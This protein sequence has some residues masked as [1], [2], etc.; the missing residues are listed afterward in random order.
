M[1]FPRR[2]L[3]LLLLAG[4]LGVA[5][6]AAAQDSKEFRGRVLATPA[7][8]GLSVPVLTLGGYGVDSTLVGDS[9]L[10]GWDSRAAA[11]TRFDGILGGY[12]GDNAPDVKWVLPEA[13]RRM[14]KRAPSMVP[15]PDR[16]GHGVMSSERIKRIPDPLASRLRQL[17]AMSDA[18][19]VFI[20]SGLLLK[21][22]STGT[23]QAE[24]A[25]QLVDARLGDVL[26]RTFATGKGRS[27]DAAVRA[28]IAT[29][30]PPEL[31]P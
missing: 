13:L 6:P 20:P 15:D 8:A 12:L 11:I 18:R 14:A 17:V 16:L 3:G 5:A 25:A 30:V 28:A 9:T 4:A 2:F 10:A 19:Q 22:D 7:L 1:S 27:P 23:V 21:R 24:L 29:M 31:N 26:W